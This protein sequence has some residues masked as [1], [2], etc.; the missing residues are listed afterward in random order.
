[1]ALSHNQPLWK[2]LNVTYFLNVT[3][4]RGVVKTGAVGAKAPVDFETEG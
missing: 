2:V 4:N 3:F 1:M